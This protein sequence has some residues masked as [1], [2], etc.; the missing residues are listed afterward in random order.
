MSDYDTQNKR[1]LAALKAGRSF[2]RLQAMHEL[3]IGNLPAR[4]LELRQMGEPVADKWIRAENQ[5]GGMSRFKS[6]HMAPS[7]A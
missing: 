2:T 7:A 3:S 4:V 1:L 5:F 6:Y